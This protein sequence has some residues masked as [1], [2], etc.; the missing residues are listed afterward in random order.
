M[1]QELATFYDAYKDRV[2]FIHVEPYELDKARSGQ[3]LVPIRTMTE[4]GLHT[5]PWIFVV[6]KDGKVA[7]KF[8][9][10][11]MTDEIKSALN[12]VLEVGDGSTMH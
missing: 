3:A 5:E 11:V 1:T 4:W 12:G 9:A 6:D 2:I 10:F 7:A 8:E